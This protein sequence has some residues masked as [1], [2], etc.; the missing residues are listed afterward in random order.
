MNNPEPFGSR[1]ARCVTDI[2]VGNGNQTDSNS[3]E[4]ISTWRADPTESMPT[5]HRRAVWAQ[6]PIMPRRLLQRRD[7]RAFYA[8]ASAHHSASCGGGSSHSIQL[9]QYSTTH[10]PT[11]TRCN[12]VND[13]GGNVPSV[14]TRSSVSVCIPL[15][16]NADSRNAGK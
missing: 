12:G 11:A 2:D 10:R 3:S 9:P 4:V 5:G 16:P 6:K 14:S 7:Q 8:P 13:S 1:S 15:D